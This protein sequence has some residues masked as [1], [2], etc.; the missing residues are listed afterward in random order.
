MLAKCDIVVPLD[1]C[2]AGQAVR[3]RQSQRIEYLCATDRERVTAVGIAKW[4]S[5]TKAMTSEIR[6]SLEQEGEFT[7]PALHRRLGEAKTGLL[8]Q[9]HYANLSQDSIGRPPITLRRF[10]AP[11]EGT[12]TAMTPQTIRQEVYLKLSLLDILNKDT[13]AS[14]MNWL[15]KDSPSSLTDIQLVNQVLGDAQ[16]TSQ[17]GAELLSGTD[18]V[19]VPSLGPSGQQQAARLL[20]GLKTSLARIPSSTLSDVNTK[21]SVYDVR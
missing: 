19:I 11:D 9:P 21:D 6:R 7:L 20:D 3:A 2:Y 15:T 1:C 17:L 4:P 16:D 10:T 5:F 18:G 8:A 12:P 13:M 14:L